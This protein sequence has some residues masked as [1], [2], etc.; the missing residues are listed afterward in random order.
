VRFKK[1]NLGFGLT[2]RGAYRVLVERLD[3][4]RSLGRNTQRRE[5]NIKMDIQKVGWG[6]YTGLIC[7]RTETGDKNSTVFRKKQIGCSTVA[8]TTI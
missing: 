7:L 4:K 1:K 5:G 2:V 3:A 6:I 8:I